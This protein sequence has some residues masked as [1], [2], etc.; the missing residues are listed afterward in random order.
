[1]KLSKK[2]SPYLFRLGLQKYHR[3]P[4]FLLI[5][6]VLRQLTLNYQP[7]FKILRHL[8][9]PANLKPLHDCLL[10]CIAA[11]CKLSWVTRIRV[12]IDP[13]HPLVCGTCKRRL[14]GAVFRMR[15]EKPRPCV[16]AGVV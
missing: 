13:L 11:A 3:F 2:K 15:Q 1:L 16:T 10:T 6:P 12:R 14:H 9:T 5:S 4:F 7:K 8:F